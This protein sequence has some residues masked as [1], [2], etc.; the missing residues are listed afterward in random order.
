MSVANPKRGF[1]NVRH[2]FQ[3]KNGSLA[4]LK[5]LG[6]VLAVADAYQF[7]AWDRSLGGWVLYA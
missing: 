1:F 5:T 3:F 4:E 6:D 2:Y 7:R